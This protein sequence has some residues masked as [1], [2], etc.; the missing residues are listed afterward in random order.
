MWYWLV[1][2]GTEEEV[3]Q[4]NFVVP[5]VT[6]ADSPAPPSQPFL[7]PVIHLEDG[8]MM[9]RRRQPMAV[10]WWPKSDFTDI[11]MLKVI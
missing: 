9:R 3:S 10:D 7:S 4:H 1:Q 6:P 2:Q 5:V 11:L 8:R